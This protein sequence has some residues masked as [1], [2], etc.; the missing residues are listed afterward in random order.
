MLLLNYEPNGCLNANK[1]A[2]LGWCIIQ[3]R[4]LTEERQKGTA[5]QVYSVF[6]DA[7]CAG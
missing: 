2:A 7:F 6:P 5:I 1:D 3:I 4:M